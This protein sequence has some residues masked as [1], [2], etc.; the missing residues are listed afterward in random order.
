VKLQLTLSLLITVLAPL[1]AAVAAVRVFDFSSAF[2]TETNVE[3]TAIGVTS[4]TGS[5]NLTVTPTGNFIGGSAAANANADA[6]RGDW[7]LGVLNKNDPTGDRNTLTNRVHVDGK[8]GAEFIRLEFNE[9][10]R[11]TSVI[12]SFVGAFQKFDLA[13]DGKDVNVAGV[14]GTDEILQLAPPNMLPGTVV[15]PDTLAF[16]KTWDFFA[17]NLGDEWSI[18]SKHSPKGWRCRRR[19]ELISGAKR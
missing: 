6:I 18:E 9:K 12:F 5:P 2:L 13:I 19:E 14:L 1:N 7:G 10:V 8:N 4:T 3:G 15:F 11:V 17:P 16:G